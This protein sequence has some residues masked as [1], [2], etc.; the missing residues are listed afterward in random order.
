MITEH[1]PREEWQLLFMGLGK[2]QTTRRTK[3]NP[4]FSKKVK[5]A[6]KVKK[7]QKSKKA[8]KSKKK[9]QNAKKKIA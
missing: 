1:L 9:K 7:G 8:K 6:K 4:K 2:T 3:G 5:K